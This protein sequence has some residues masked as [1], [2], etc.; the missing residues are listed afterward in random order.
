MGKFQ[1]KTKDERRHEIM[2]A[3]KRVFIKKG[4]R[5]STMEDV[6][7]NTSLS[8]GGVYQYY[9]NTKSIMFDIMK[10]GN[11][12]RFLKTEDIIGKFSS[13]EDVFEVMTQIAIA[14]LF[15]DIPEKKL[16][17]MFLSE[18]MYD[19]ETEKLFYKLE[20]EGHSYLIKNL[21]S[22]PQFSSAKA[23]SEKKVALLYSRIFNGILIIY[24]LLGDKNPF[25]ENQKE[26]HDF[27]YNL[28]KKIIS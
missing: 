23:E 5:Y 21:E 22:I 25:L 19:K 3:A 17:I 10:E 13:T 18:I 12:T 26:L 8:K 1:R 14:K 6:I 11:F 9:K 4:Y 20:S 16:Y 15:E 7:A 27:I 24:E 28:M 2:D